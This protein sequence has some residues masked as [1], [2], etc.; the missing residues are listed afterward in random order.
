MNM[1]GNSE[2]IRNMW[3]KVFNLSPEL[4]MCLPAVRIYSHEDHRGLSPSV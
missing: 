2:H 4:A 1:Q 3:K